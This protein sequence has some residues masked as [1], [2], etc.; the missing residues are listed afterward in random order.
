MKTGLIIKREYLSRVK[1]KSFVLMTILGP[2]LM[3]AVIFVRVWLS[4]VPEETLT[5]QVIDDARIFSNRLESSKNLRLIYS[6][7][8]LQSAQENFYKNTYDVIVYIPSNILESQIV[9]IFYKKQPPLATQEYIKSQVKN[10]VEELKL[11]ASG[12]DR[13]Q[14]EGIKTDIR[15][16]A[17][18]LEAS[19]EQ[20]KRNSEASLA[21][22]FLGSMLIYFFIFLYGAQVMR[23]VIEEKTT[24]I[25]EV[26]ISS[27]RPFELMMGKIIGIALVGLTQFALWLLLTFG[28]VYG[29]VKFV[30]TTKF[31]PEKLEETMKS[32]QP[33][34]GLSAELGQ[35]ENVQPELEQLG[36]FTEGINLP[37]IVGSFLA[38]FLGGYLLYAALFAAVG[39][40]VDSDADTQQFMLPVTIPMIL[41]ITISQTVITN[42]QSSIA[43]WFSMFPLTSPI[44]MMVRI[45]FGV[46][47]WEVTLSL[48]LL[49]AGF[50]F[51]TWLSARI[52]RTG[53]LMYGKKSSYKELWKW[54]FYKD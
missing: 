49:I 27:V 20:K 12:I 29:A 10:T 42:P 15:L 34:N 1:K 44:I 39:S 33:T 51:T 18:Q 45:P 17:S 3:A 6:D 47:V 37:V 5:V 28:L 8:K 46:P 16:Q 13:L 11:L 14:L 25:V 21:L 24:R 36:S 32:S 35:N 53:I 9:Q 19:G 7:E 50:L 41:A 40:A 43:F 30:N 48:L 54:L 23:G 26:I 22:G 38:F 31:N 52:Y 4:M 2:V